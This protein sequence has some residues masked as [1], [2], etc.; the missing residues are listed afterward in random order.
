MP[1]RENTVEICSFH[2]WTL[3][4]RSGTEHKV[5][6]VELAPLIATKIASFDRLRRYIQLFS[7]AAGE[8]IDPTLFMEFF[9]P[10]ETI[11]PR[12]EPPDGSIE[13]EVAKSNSRKRCRTGWRTR[14]VL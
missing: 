7:D 8:Y 10:V 9:R 12:P 2:S 6:E 13:Q 5:V 1:K 14:G 3:W 11:T 4:T